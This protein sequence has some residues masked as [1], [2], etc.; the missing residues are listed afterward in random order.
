MFQILESE[1]ETHNKEDIVNHVFEGFQSAQ[2]IRRYSRF[3][4]IVVVSAGRLYR[5]RIENLSKVILEEMAA[6]WFDFF[7]RG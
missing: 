3:C 6:K 4:S 1:R 7:E 2:G 5:T